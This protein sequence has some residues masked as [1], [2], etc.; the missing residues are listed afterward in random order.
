MVR[1]SDDFLDDPTRRRFN[2]DLVKHMAVA[3][4]FTFGLA[5]VLTS[6]LY[7]TATNTA[8]A[9]L[10][11]VALLLLSLAIFFEHG[12]SEAR[13]APLMGVIVKLGGLVSAIAA[14]GTFVVRF[15]HVG[16]FIDVA[17]LVTVGIGNCFALLFVGIGLFNT[18]V[19]RSTF[20]AR[21]IYAMAAAA[22]LVGGTSGF[23][24]AAVDVEDHVRR[25]GWEQWV[26]AS[27]GC[28]AGAAIGHAN[29]FAVDESMSITFDGIPM[30]DDVGE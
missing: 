3:G 19:S 27:I 4:T 25:L 30:S 11:G 6:V 22:V 14:F 12:G 28:V 5:I 10:N 7:E 2:G 21:Q 23:F 1:E 20:V 26:C 29:H 17:F 24:F 16:P 13:A 8:F 9:A 18:Y 15:A